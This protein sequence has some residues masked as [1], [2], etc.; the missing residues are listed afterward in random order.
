MKEKVMYEL[1]LSKYSHNYL[2]EV[3]ILVTDIKQRVCYDASSYG[4][5]TGHDYDRMRGPA[6][7]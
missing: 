3:R 5:L 7:A 4:A 2:E 6:D 1:F